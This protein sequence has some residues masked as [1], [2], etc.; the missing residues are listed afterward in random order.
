M[1]FHTHD[2]GQATGPIPLTWAAQYIGIPFGPEWDCW[3]LVVRCYRDWLQI[4]L[5]EYGDISAGEL[6]RV[7]RA[8]GAD[9]GCPPWREIS[10]ENVQP[11]D[12]VLMSGRVNRK[13]VAMHVGLAVNNKTVLHV[14][15]GID[16]VAVP[17]THQSVGRRILGYHRHAQVVCFR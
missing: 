3:R 8:M 1:A 16:T 17:F 12:V 10:R 9:S 11:F 13:R 2:K 7:A 14:E 6:I 5:P 4:E 15:Q